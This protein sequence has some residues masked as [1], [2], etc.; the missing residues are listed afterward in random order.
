MTKS[1]PWILSSAA[2]SKQARAISPSVAAQII[3]KAERPLVVV[4]AAITELEGVLIKKISQ[5]VS[6]GM[7][8][9]ATAHSLKYFPD[10]KNVHEMGIAEI[11]NLLTDK[12]WR[13]LDGKGSYDVVVFLGVEYWLLS[14]IANT[15]RNFTDI[16]TLNIS[17]YYQPNMTFS[18]P[19]ITDE[20]WVEH[21]DEL[22]GFLK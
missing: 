7:P 13:G 18:F 14:L 3:K 9:V 11:T 22:I 17:R 16:T 20:I 6:L 4:G 12:E 21:L 10:R 5:I 1:T 8:L 15:L 2:G 19:N